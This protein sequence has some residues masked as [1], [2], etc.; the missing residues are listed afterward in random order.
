MGTQTVRLELPGDPVE[1]PGAPAQAAAMARQ[2]LIVE[3]LREA[4]VSQGLAARLLGLTR[5]QILDL[6]TERGIP[7]GPETEEEVRQEFAEIHR[8]AREQERRDGG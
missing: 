4:R 2:G 5:G 8:Y 6:M 1:M 3:L 7:S